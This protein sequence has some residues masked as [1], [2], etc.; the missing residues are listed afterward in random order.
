MRVRVD[1]RGPGA[2]HAPRPA[3]PVVP[4]HLVVGPDAGAAGAAAGAGRR[5]R[6][7]T[8]RRRARAAR[9][10]RRRTAPSPRRCSATTRR[11]PRASSAAPAR[12]TTPRT[13]STTTSSRGA[14]TVNP[15]RRGTKAAAWYR[16]RVEPRETVEV[17]LRLRPPGH[18]LARDAALGAPSR[19]R[20]RAA[21]RGGG[22][23]L[24]RAHAGGHACRRGRGH[25]PGLRRDALVQAVLP[26]RRRPLAR[27]R[28]GPAPA[29]GRPPP[30]RNARWRHVRVPSTSSRC[31]TRGST[32]GSPPGTPRS[33]ASRSR[34][35]TP[36]F[37]KYQLI[38]LCREW[39]QHPDGALP[40][41]EWKFDDVNPP[42]QAW[43]ALRGLPH[44]RQP[45]PRVPGAGVREAPAQLHLVGQP[46]GR[47][48]QQP[49][50]GRLPRPGQ[51]RPHRPLAPA[52][53]LAAGAGRRHW[54]DG[55]LQR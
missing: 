10:A 34:T 39:F 8:R 41:Y 12:R 16:L 50:R 27:R 26:L 51:H 40:A 24:R 44:R 23:V 33:T 35:S 15:D 22:R 46:P 3:H 38:L 45:R 42:V 13:A 17:R 47:R 37:A 20:A 7:R 4:Q 19:G 55:L 18:G 32:R 14:A 2:G 21:A 49:L 30:G 43:A 36:A 29:A 53:G 48:R 25:A 11:T 9:R 6:R 5:S 31:P 52:R 1:Q 28:P 54:L